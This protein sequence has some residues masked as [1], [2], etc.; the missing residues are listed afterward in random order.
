MIDKEQ[1][2]F[3]CPQ[4]GSRQL[5]LSTCRS[6]NGESVLDLR[7]ERNRD[8]LA[9]I[10]LRQ[11]QKLES[12]IRWAGVFG[13]IAAVVALWMI[14]GFWKARHTYLCCLINLRSWCSWPC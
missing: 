9:D 13:S 8:L 2:H 12:I 3:A 1:Q 4:C 10:D 6:C 14:P 7:L 11:R 5:E